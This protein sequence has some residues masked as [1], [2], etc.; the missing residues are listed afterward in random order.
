LRA[1][2]ARVRPHELQ[3]DDQRF[4]TADQEE[5]ERAHPIEDADPLVIDGGEPREHSCC[6]GDREAGSGRGWAAIERS[7]LHSRR[8]HFNP[9]RYA[10][11]ALACSSVRPRSGIFAPGLSRCGSCTHA[12]TLSDVFGHMPAASV[13]RP[14][15]WLRFGP[16]TPDETP[17]IVWQPTHALFVTLALPP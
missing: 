10:A 2:D 6:R 9:L 11:T 13:A 7:R 14:P 1:H 15:K 4:D 8:H 16:S 3:P 12:A 17:A 5:G